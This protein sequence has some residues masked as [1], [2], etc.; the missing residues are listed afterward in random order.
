MVAKV[1]FIG[2]I[3]LNKWNWENKS[4]STFGGYYFSADINKSY[5]DRGK[6]LEP[7]LA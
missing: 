3:L 2:N 5:S 7:S 6:L 4:Q 1:L